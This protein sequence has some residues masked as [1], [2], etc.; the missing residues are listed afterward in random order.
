MIERRMELHT[1]EQARK[2]AK[3]FNAFENT[4]KVWGACV[5]WDNKKCVV[6]SFYNEASAKWGKQIRQKF[7]DVYGYND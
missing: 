3:I 1:E 7:D 2:L 5:P 6:V 4:T